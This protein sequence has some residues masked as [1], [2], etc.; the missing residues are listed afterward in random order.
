MSKGG[1]L[2]VVADAFFGGTAPKA[3]ELVE[4]HGLRIDTNDA[5]NLML[6]SKITPDLLTQG[7]SKL[8]FYRPARV[9]AADPKQARL[10][11]VMAEDEAGGFIAVSRA[12]GRGNVVLLAQSLWWNWIRSEG[13]EG[14]NA[15]MLE[16]LLSP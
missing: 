8:S 16:N 10:L 13:S 4:R 5:G 7:V 12:A 3:N 15:R 11:A 14:D 6:T 2:I 1:R 9:W